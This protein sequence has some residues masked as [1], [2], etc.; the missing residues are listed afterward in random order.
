MA[1]KGGREARTVFAV[2]A[3]RLLVGLTV[4]QCFAALALGAE[5][6]TLTF[7][8]KVLLADGSPAAGAIVERQGINQH[9][10]FTTHANADGYFQTSARFEDGV[11]LHVRAPDGGQQAIYTLGE[12]SVRE[13][14]RTRQE[15]KLRP[16]TT[17]KV[18][19]AVAGKPIANAEVIV[20][21]DGFTASG[22][23]DGVGQ[24][25]ARLPTGASLRSVAAYHP[26]SGV[27]GQYLEGS[28]PKETYKVDL[29]PPAPHEI[30][31][32]DDNG[33]PIADLEFG[34]N[35]AVGD[36]WLWFQ[37]SAPP[38]FGPTKPALRRLPGCPATTCT[39]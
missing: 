32:I 14:V 35:V 4:L 39:P 36:D 10:T 15:I 16:A 18:S 28:V 23:T 11:H 25:E 7:T 24:A 20:T 9:R 3:V 34:V 22:K 21:G 30:R 31:M 6:D 29:L 27:G 1:N 37:R 19:V 17:H 26:S 33:R 13:A 12:S 2:R 8:G 38:E 5:A